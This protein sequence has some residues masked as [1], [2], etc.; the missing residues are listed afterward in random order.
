MTLA[1]RAVGEGCS[2]R[3]R[4]LMG[5]T[6]VMMREEGREDKDEERELV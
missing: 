1:E 5:G 6:D 2:M 3:I 4:E